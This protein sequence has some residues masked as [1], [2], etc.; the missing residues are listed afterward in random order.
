MKY[1]DI[2]AAKAKERQL[3]ELVQNKKSP[4]PSNEG[5]GNKPKNKH[6]VS[7]D[8]ELGKIAGTSESSIARTRTI[9]TKGTPED[10][11]E[12]AEGKA[13][14]YGKSQEIKK[15]E[16]SEPVRQSGKDLSVI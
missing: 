8:A 7:A 9:L 2:I 16:K 12:V 6:S 5:N 13:S 15:R 1:K 3:A 11:Q 4:L 10:I 14:I